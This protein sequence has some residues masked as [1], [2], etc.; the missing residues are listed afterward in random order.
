MANTLLE[1][2]LTSLIIS[3]MQ[4]EPTLRDTTPKPAEWLLPLLTERRKERKKQTNVG[5]DVEELEPL[6][7]AGGME[8]GAAIAKSGMAV[9]QMVRERITIWPSN[10]TSRYIPPKN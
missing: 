3:E 6:C 5:E 1:R 4:I 2:C 8:N 10:P 9:P 7:V